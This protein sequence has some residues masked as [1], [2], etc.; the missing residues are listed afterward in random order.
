MAIVVQLFNSNVELPMAPR[1]IRM[2]TCAYDAYVITSSN[3]VVI[4]SEPDGPMGM[5]VVAV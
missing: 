4:P 1:S 2:Y 5:A 3:Y